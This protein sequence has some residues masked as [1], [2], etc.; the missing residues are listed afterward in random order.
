[1]DKNNFTNYWLKEE[2]DYSFLKTQGFYI[3][4]CSVNDEDGFYNKYLILYKNGIIYGFSFYAFELNNKCE[5]FYKDEMRE[6]SERRRNNIYSWGAFTLNQDSISIQRPIGLGNSI[7][8]DFYS[9][10]EYK[11][12]VLNDSTFA[13]TVSI[14]LDEGRVRE[15][16]ELYHFVPCQ[17][18]DSLSWL[19][20]DKKLNRLLEK[21][22]SKSVMKKTQKKEMT[23][24]RF[25]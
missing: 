11:G 21:H 13:L 10:T 7:F 2:N 1:M 25:E 6:N 14:D 9:I 19:L 12:Q 23:K 4:E 22:N 8:G 15:V 17:K 20:T 16:D 18:P 3:C 5:K 24:D